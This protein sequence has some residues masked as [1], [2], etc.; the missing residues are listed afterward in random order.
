[1]S[2][3]P[4]Y[5]ASTPAPTH[6]GAAASP[7]A[8]QVG[9]TLRLVPT[10]SLPP[11]PHADG[12]I[13]F[14]QPLTL[15]REQAYMTEALASGR[16]SGDGPFT[17]RCRALLEATLAHTLAQPDG[18]TTLRQP[19]A[20][21]TTSCTHALEMAALALN[22]QPGDEV[23]V[24]SFTFVSTAN[25]FALRG[26]TIVFADVRPDTLNLDERQLPDLLTPRT[27]AVV[28]VHYAGVACAMDEITAATRDA[29]QRHGKD[30]DIV[31]DNAHGLFGTYKG[32][33]LGTIGRLGT[34]SFHDTKNFICGEGG[35]L[36]INDPALLNAGEMIREKGT[37]R[38][39]FLRGEV[40]K[41]TWRRVGSSYLLGDVLAAFLLAQLEAR[42]AVLHHRRR[43]WHRY[44]D[45]LRHWAH[46][47]GVQQ[48]TVPEACTP[49]WH[50]YHL[51]MPD[52]SARD[53]LIDHLKAHD[54]P[55]AFHYVPLHT[56]D[57]GQRLGGRRGQCP[58]TES[59]AAHLVR[60]PF[61]N[62]LSNHQADRV[63]DAVTAF[64]P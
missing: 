21:L 52:E 15:G 32:R 11:D 45:A 2:Q 28:P 29:T 58:V 54:I 10:P 30:V 37:D 14:N 35:A 48:P 26:A 55:A 5:P 31:E 53:A 62:A 50:L 47:H 46:D 51:L 6:H 19:A 63:I 27:R 20:L 12:P 23:V 57:M 60:L 33:P 43:L 38:S 44:Q 56:S 22:I 16:L 24:P 36:L 18:G 7:D 4:A 42:D 61:H 3:L 1:M 25:A 9:T 59:A 64:R 17:K 39:R 41:Y 34:Q 13:R 40:D 49:A 8:A